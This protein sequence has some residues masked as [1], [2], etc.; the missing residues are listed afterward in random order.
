MPRSADARAAPGLA[1]VR[2]SRATRRLRRTLL[3]L[4]S[5]LYVGSIPWYRRP[6]GEVSLW[7]GLPD[8]VA[9][10][11]LCYLAV[12]VLNALAW[13]LTD[14]SDGVEEETRPR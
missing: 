10:A 5:L 6:D 3:L 11:M 13:L 4:I 7:L 8:W 2:Q 12:A 1:A 9:A 14:V